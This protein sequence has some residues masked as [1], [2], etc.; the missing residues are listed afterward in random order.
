MSA[1]KIASE[2]EVSPATVQNKTLKERKTESGKRKEE[3][4]GSQI[5][6]YDER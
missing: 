4:N 3:Q 6:V 5:V 2:K 1:R